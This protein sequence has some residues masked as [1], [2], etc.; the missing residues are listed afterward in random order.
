MTSG[1]TGR[2][3]RGGRS[4]VS[5]SLVGSPRLEE[6]DAEVGR[7]VL[8]H[9]K[10]AVQ[11]AVS[12]GVESTESVSRSVTSHH[13]FSH[14]LRVDIVLCTTETQQRKRVRETKIQGDRSEVRRIHMCLQG[15]PLLGG[16]TLLR[17]RVP[18]NQEAVRRMRRLHTHIALVGE[19][20]YAS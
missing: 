14:Q 1:L 7:Q 20:R 17:V 4:K 2:V 18:Y 19:L 16:C 13:D 6:T 10:L 12:L 5:N 15:G 3:D 9:L 11:A 8:V